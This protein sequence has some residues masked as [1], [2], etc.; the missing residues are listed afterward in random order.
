MAQNFFAVD[1]GAVA[2]AHVFEDVL[3]VR[4]YDAR[5]LSAD[6]TVAKRQL[7]AGLP[8]DAEGHGDNFHFAASTAGFY[9]NNSRS[10]GHG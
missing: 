2:A 10:A 7:V 5:L 4:R 9:Q 8:P 1:V 3:A 6:A